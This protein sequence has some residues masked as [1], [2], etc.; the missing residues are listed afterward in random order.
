MTVLEAMR[1]RHTVRK[2][3]DIAL[4]EEN[5]KMLNERIKENNQKYNLNMKLMINNKKALS[6]IAKLIFA[7][8]VKNYFILAGDI[9]S[10]LEEKLGYCSADLMLYAQ[11]LGLNTWYIGSM[12]NS[13]VAQFVDGK[14]VV[15]I[16]AVGYG[17]NE[18]MPHKSKTILEVSRYEGEMPEWFKKGVE[19]ALFAPTAFNKQEFMISGKGNEVHIENDND[20]FTGVIRGLIK[21]YFELGAG[22]NSFKWI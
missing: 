21:Y 5:I 12:F 13:K 16:I 2:Y 22:I 10:D 15:G 20:I 17:S 7:K 18:G 14:K 3:K 6:T 4:T 11:T 8:G 19:A 1:K 9:S